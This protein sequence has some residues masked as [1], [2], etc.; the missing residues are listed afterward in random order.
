MTLSR[1]HNTK[2]GRSKSAY[3]QKLREGKVD[4][5]LFDPILSDHKRASV[6]R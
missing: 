4:G 3:G 2:H 6:K 1:K 5:R